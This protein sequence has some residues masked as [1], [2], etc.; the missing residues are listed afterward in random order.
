MTKTLIEVMP[1][2]FRTKFASEE[3]TQPRYANVKVTKEHFGDNN[4][5]PGKH[6]H[7]YYWVELENGYAV[8]WNENPAKGWSFPYLKL[9]KT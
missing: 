6:K 8:G 2:A 4:H 1:L 5:W 9:P 3:Y 7:V